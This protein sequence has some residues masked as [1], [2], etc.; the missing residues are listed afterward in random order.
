MVNPI[1]TKA[2]ETPTILIQL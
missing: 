2:Y 1:S